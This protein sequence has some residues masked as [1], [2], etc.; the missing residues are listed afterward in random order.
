MAKK[1]KKRRKRPAG[2]PAGKPPP[3]PDAAGAAEAAAAASQG[4]QRREAARR[5][6]EA[7]RRRQTVRRIVIGA[8][9]LILLVAVF[10]GRWWLDRREAQQYQALAATAGC[11]EVQEPG[12]LGRDH[13][14]P[15][16]Q[17]PDYESSPPVG[18]DHSPTTLPA[19]VYNEPL[20][21]AT[22]AVTEDLLRTQPS[23][24]RAVHSLEHGYIIVWHNE[25]PD[26]ELSAVE[27]AIRG[28]QK[29][30]LAPYPELED[31]RVALTAWGR[32]QICDSGDPD[33]VRAFIERFREAT[34]PEP[35]AP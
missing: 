20:V 22:G 28:Q 29:I 17:P 27:R 12:G 33:V 24:Y 26:D 30:I 19:G 25:L 35:N 3:R 21:R 2:P 10:G 4:D 23:I 7:Q 14:Q 34:A 1:K 32:L 31:G 13:L 18:G 9:V 6:R 5:R 16:Q 11:G 8:A 15:E